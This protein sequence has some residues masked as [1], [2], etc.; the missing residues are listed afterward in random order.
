MGHNYLQ[1]DDRDDYLKQFDTHKNNYLMYSIKI[2]GEWSKWLGFG[3]IRNIIRRKLGVST[4]E[5]KAFTKNEI[6]EKAKLFDLEIHC[7]RIPYI[8]GYP[9]YNGNNGKDT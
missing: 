2:N 7:E 1:T 4:K 6:L 3:I 9:L 8:C 5:I